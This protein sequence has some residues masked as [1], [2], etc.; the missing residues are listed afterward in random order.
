MCRIPIC[1][2]FLK[3]GRARSAQTDAEVNERILVILSISIA[4]TGLVLLQTYREYARIT[5]SL[6]TLLGLVAS[7]IAIYQF[8]KGR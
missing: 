7:G 1:G 4:A 3:N 6:M 2:R 8:L 5:E